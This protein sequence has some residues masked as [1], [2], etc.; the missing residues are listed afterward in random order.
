MGKKMYY[1]YLD[2]YDTGCFNCMEVDRFHRPDYDGMK[3]FEEAVTGSKGS[4]K[5]MLCDECFKSYDGNRITFANAIID[6]SNPWLPDLTRAEID[7]CT[8]CK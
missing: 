5:K 6:G 7:D 8:G 4:L 1:H 2:M 3:D